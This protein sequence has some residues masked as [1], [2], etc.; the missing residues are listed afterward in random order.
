[1]IELI[2]VT[3]RPGY[4]LYVEYNDGATG[5]VDLS[6]LVG[7]G[8]FAAWNDPGVFEAVSIGEH[9]EIRWTEDLELCA[10]AMYLQITGKCAEDIFPN[11][12]APAD[13]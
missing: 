3:P 11:L 2:G 13:A 6:H 7:Q 12:K 4:K 9:G 8:V 5:E 1:M 10:D